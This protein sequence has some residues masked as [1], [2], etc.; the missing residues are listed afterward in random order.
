LITGDALNVS[1]GL[2]AGP[3]PA[4]TPDVATALASLKKLAAYDIETVI[5]YHG[6]VYRGDANRRIAVLSDGR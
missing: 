4:Y 2:L 1:D 5:C 6:G 3:N